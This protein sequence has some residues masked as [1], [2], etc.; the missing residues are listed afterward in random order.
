MYTKCE[1]II[2]KMRMKNNKFKIMRKFLRDDNNQEKYIWENHNDIYH[3]RKIKL[4]LLEIFRSYFLVFR[5]CCCC[6]SIFLNSMWY[7]L[8]TRKRNGCGC[9][10]FLY[11]VFFCVSVLKIVCIFGFCICHNLIVIY[12]WIYS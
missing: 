6:N 7:I 2:M 11:F 1:S 10:W 9:V 5:C 12:I 8:F 4:L 3:W